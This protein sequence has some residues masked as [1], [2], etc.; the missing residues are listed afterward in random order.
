MPAN[1][2]DFHN[3]DI[4]IKGHDS[5]SDALDAGGPWTIEAHMGD[6]RV[7][8][9]EGKNEVKG[10]WVDPEHRRKGIGSAMHR[11][12]QRLGMVHS[13]A[14]T[15]EGEAWAK[16]TPDNFPRWLKIDKYND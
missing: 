5:V 12:A 15:D 10:I 8:Y 7:G 6:K 1:N 14:R 2:A 3:V 16:S 13:T 11:K 9:L 4:S